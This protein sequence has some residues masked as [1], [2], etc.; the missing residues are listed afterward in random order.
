[1]CIGNICRSPTAEY[2]L[3]EAIL[4]AR[5]DSDIQVSSA[6][7]SALVDHPLESTAQEVLQEQGNQPMEHEARQLKSAL[8]SESDL[9][10]VTE[11]R[12]IKCLTDI[13]PEAQG[14]VLL[15]GKWQG[16]QK[17]DM[18][19]FSDVGSMLA[20]PVKPKKALIALIATLLGAF[21]SIAFVLVRKALNRWL[22]NPEAI[23]QLGLPVYA[24]IPYSS[25]Q[26]AEEDKNDRG[27]RRANRAAPLLT[28]SH[29]TDLV[30]E[31]LRCLRTSL[32]FAMME[33]NNNRL[34]ISGPSPQVGRTLVSAKHSPTWPSL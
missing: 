33:S 17:N 22:R 10:L 26:K 3:R 16:D 18:L 19:G 8:V 5:P 34:M 12:H 2:L 20:K 13:A 28:M 14:K 11:K 24:S 30:V 6:G 15:L 23:E 31:A 29:P 4:K 9:I 21:L 25:L 1:M 32:H 27:R 7:L